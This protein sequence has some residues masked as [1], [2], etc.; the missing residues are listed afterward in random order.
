MHKMFVPECYIDTCL[1]NAFL[2]LPNKKGVNHQK[3]VSV[4]IN[5][6]EEYFADQFSVGLIDRDK[7]QNPKFKE[8][9]TLINDTI[10]GYALLFKHKTKHHYVI[11]LVP[12]AEDWICNVA[13]EIGIDLIN[14]HKIPNNPKE[15]SKKTKTITSN[16]DETFI[17]L[18]KSILNESEKANFEPVVKMKNWISLLASSKYSV[19]INELIK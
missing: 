5:K 12:E 3:G 13:G 6:M 19:D 1:L 16:Y 15:L 10:Q 7:K 9:F 17:K 4:V 2:N 11:Q 8:S 18:F 14:D